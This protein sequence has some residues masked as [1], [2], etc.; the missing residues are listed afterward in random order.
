MTDQS[1]RVPRLTLYEE[2]L[3]LAL[4][5][6]KGTPFGST[7]YSF[8]MGGAIVSELLF[9]G[10]I[11]LVKWKKT[12][13]VEVVESTPIGDPLLDESLE[14]VALSRKQKNVVDWLSTFANTKR[15]RHR[16]AE[17]LVEK[18]VLRQ[19][20][21]RVLWIFPRRTYPLAD[22][23]PKRDLVDRL[24]RTVVD[25]ELPDART[26]VVLSLAY[27]TGLLA[28]VLGKRTVKERKDAIKLMIEGDAV[29]GAA[30]AAIQAA[31]AAQAAVMMSMPR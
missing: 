28:R 5:D 31:Q 12:Q 8:G 29:G 24:R 10:R 16:V 15:L 3:L 4:H 23:E 18:G 13:R 7:S 25:G 26:L 14:K 9:A 20:E 2:V 6:E 11:R 1:V 27:S 19:V 17:R 30:K 22:P 21:G